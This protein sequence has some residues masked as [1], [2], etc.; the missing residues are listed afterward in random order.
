MATDK[1]TKNNLSIGDL[2]NK[3]LRLVAV[4]WNCLEDTKIDLDKF[5]AATGYANATS[6]RVCLNG[7]KRK[8]LAFFN[9]LNKEGDAATAPSPKR[10]GADS[11]ADESAPAAKK[12]KAARKPRVKAKKDVSEDADA[13][14]DA[15]VKSSDHDL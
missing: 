13:Q 7:T 12:A 2:T 11:T 14:E 10:K 3:D 8:L 5:T 9:S 15:D 4:A 1:G 6:A